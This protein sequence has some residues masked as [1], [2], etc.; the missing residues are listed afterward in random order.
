[1]I[2]RQ[3]AE[4][5]TP[6]LGPKMLTNDY[7]TSQPPLRRQLEPLSK[8]FQTDEEL[9]DYFEMK[10]VDAFDRNEEDINNI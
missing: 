3:Q 7:R 10:A 2:F 9:L 4:A 6:E 5:Q 8:R 1:M